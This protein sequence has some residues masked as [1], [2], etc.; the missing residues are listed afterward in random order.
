MAG[1]PG[2]VRG[3]APAGARPGHR[4]RRGDRRRPARGGQAAAAVRE[5]GRFPDGARDQQRRPERR[6]DPLH[7]SGHGRVSLKGCGS[8]RQYTSEGS[9]SSLACKSGGRN[10][11]EARLRL[12][13]GEYHFLYKHGTGASVAVHSYSSGSRIKPG[14]TYTSCTYVVES[15]YGL[16]ALPD[17]SRQPCASGFFSVIPADCVVTG[18]PFRFG[19]HPAHRRVLRFS[20]GPAEQSRSRGNGPFPDRHARTTGQRRPEQYPPGCTHFRTFTSKCPSH[21]SS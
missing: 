19:R 9:G 21:G 13:A 6:R 16:A 18:S 4:H 7:R 14:Y 10:Y 15:S 1:G 12:P 20:C 8:C 5:S 11:P 2:A 3:A 17:Q